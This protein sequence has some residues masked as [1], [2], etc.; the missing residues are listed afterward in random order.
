[1]PPTPDLTPSEGG[2]SLTRD[3]G[4]ATGEP[5][6]AARERAVAQS[7]LELEAVMKD[8][9]EANENLVI[10]NLKSQALASEIGLLYEEATEAIQAKN[11]FFEQVSHEL[12]SPMT[13]ISGWAALLGISPDPATIAEAA[14]SIASS[15][16][17]QVK[18]VNDLL[19]VSRI[20]TQ[21]FEITRAETDFRMVAEEALIAIH[22]A[23]STK[24]ISVKK[25]SPYPIHVDADA[26]RLRQVL[27]NLL[28][29]AVKFTPEGGLIETS[30]TLDGTDAVLELRDDGEGIPAHFLPHVF[31]RHTQAKARRFGG[32]GLGLAIVKHIVD[33][34]GGSV[35]AES[36]GEGKGATFTIRI[37]GARRG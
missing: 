4:P 14:R 31:E 25:S 32:L 23:A 24:S 22:P 19:D 11:A 36:A 9:R 6:V 7:W 21:K 26:I 20:M 35:L 34:H 30:L 13:S 15:S 28:S 33:L 12:R 37:P 16:A 29:N 10:A 17:V 8:L 1:M 3:A 27:D 18:L 5:S 2:A